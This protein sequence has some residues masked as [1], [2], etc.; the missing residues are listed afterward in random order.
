M[1]FN[2]LFNYR[3]QSY[4]SDDY[5]I[6]FQK[7]ENSKFFNKNFAYLGKALKVIDISTIH[8]VNAK[9]AFFLSIL[10]LNVYSIVINIIL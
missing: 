2:K 4:Y 1:Y 10:F 9:R 7:L 6:N 3:V 5:G 8:P